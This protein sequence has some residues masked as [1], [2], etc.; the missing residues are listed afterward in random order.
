MFSAVPRRPRRSYVVTC[1]T[2]QKL[3]QVVGLVVL[4]NDGRPGNSRTRTDYIL[5][6][7]L[8]R[9]S[10]QSP[11]RAL[12]GPRTAENTERECYMM[13]MASEEEHDPEEAEGGDAIE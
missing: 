1:R 9:G 10:W 2:W 11:H 4:A 6:S 13:E 7:P 3:S 12:R 8:V 5:P